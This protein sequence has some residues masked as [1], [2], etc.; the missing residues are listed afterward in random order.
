MAKIARDQ[1]EGEPVVY[2]DEELSTLFISDPYFA[3]F[4]RWGA[5]ETDSVTAGGDQ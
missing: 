1:I 4:L 5:H 3:Y 2:Y